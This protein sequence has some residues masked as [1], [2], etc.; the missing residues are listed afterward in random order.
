[1]NKD[2]KMLYINSRSLVNKFDEIISLLLL[3]ESKWDFIFISE[4]W[5]SSDLKKCSTLMVTILFV[6]AALTDLVVVLLSMWWIILS[7]KSEQIIP[8]E[9]SYDEVIFIKVNMSRQTN[10][11][12]V[13]IYRP[14]RNNAEFLQELVSVYLR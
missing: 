10:C 5:F 3:L 7:L 1:M 2:I 6:K 13:H 4:T 11:L 8:Y 14:P 12:L 9:F